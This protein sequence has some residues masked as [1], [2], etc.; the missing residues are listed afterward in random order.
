MIKCSFTCTMLSQILPNSDCIPVFRSCSVCWALTQSGNCKDL[1]CVLTMN[2]LCFLPSHHTPP[3]PFSVSKILF[4]SSLSLSPSN[5]SSFTVLVL[6]SQ[7]PFFFT[8]NNHFS[9]MYVMVQFLFFNVFQLIIHFDKGLI[10]C[11]IRCS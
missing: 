9:I 3:I 5:S 10:T 6:L 1:D 7:S 11:P 8:C 4:I 2:M